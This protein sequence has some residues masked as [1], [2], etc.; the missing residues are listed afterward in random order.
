MILEVVPFEEN[1]LEVNVLVLA[2]SCVK[3]SVS[4]SLWQKINETNK[5]K[6]ERTTQKFSKLEKQFLFLTINICRDIVGIHSY[7]S[8]AQ[9]TF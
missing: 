1:S 2:F 4:K 5:T 9:L 7:L 8:F 6:P 3:T